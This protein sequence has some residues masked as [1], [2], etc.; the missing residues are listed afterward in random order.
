MNNQGFEKWLNIAEKVHNHFQPQI[1]WRDF[2]IEL[3]EEGFEPETAIEMVV[4]KCHKY[5]LKGR[6]VPESRNIVKRYYYGK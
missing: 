4:I 3:L 5:S 1:D 2:L 6:S